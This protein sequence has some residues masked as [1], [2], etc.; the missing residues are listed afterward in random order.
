MAGGD[1]RQHDQTEDQGGA[2][3]SDRRS[4]RITTGGGLVTVRPPGRVPGAPA[5]SG[6]GQAKGP[7]GRPRAY[8]G[9]RASRARPRRR[10]PRGARRLTPGARVPALV[11]KRTRMR[12]G[13]CAVAHSGLKRTSGGRRC[14]QKQLDL[15]PLWASDRIVW[16]LRRGRRGMPSTNKG[17]RTARLRPLGQLGHLKSRGLSHL[18]SAGNGWGVVRRG[19]PTHPTSGVG[20]AAS[21][22]KPEPRRRGTNCGGTKDPHSTQGVRP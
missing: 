21:G 13:A 4:T 2:R 12:A 10:L 20:A 1:Q 5:R 7:A 11:W 19:G 15:N 14:P 17:C 8:G 16:L 18:L 6:C 9:T 22:S 3:R